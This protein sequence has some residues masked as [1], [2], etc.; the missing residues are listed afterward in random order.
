MSGIFRDVNII[1]V[2]KVSVR[3]HYITSELDASKAYKAGKMNVALELDNRD[4][5]AGKKDIVVKLTDPAGK[6]VAEKT[7]AINFSADKEIEKANVSF[8]VKDLLA[9]TAE[10]PNLYTV[11]VIQREGG[12]DEMAFSTKYGFRHLEIFRK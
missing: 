7:V 12:K 8:D 10:T 4:K 1:N 5:L 9:W 3:D 6:L 2:P 11:S